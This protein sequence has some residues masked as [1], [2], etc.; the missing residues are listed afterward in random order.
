[1][2]GGGFVARPVA[3]SAAA[4]ACVV[5]RRWEE[6]RHGRENDHGMVSTVCSDAV[7]DSD[8]AASR[9]WGVRKVCTSDISSSDQAKSSFFPVWLCCGDL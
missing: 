4:L 8:S 7:S 1:M 2:P 9:K 3:W 6:H 5:R